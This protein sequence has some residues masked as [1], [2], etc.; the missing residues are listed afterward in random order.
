MKKIKNALI[1]VYNKNGIDKIARLLDGNGVQIY[2]TGGTHTFISKLGIEAKTIEGLTSYPSILGGRVKTLHPLVF[3]GILYQRDLQSDIE[4]I[5]EYNIPDFDLVIVDLYPFEKTVKE[6]TDEEQ[7]IE[8]IDIGGISLIR[9]AAKNFKDV[10][11]VSDYSQYPQLIEMIKQNNGSSSIEERR[12]FANFAFHT[13]SHY[14]TQ[15]FNYFNKTENLDFF[16]QSFTTSKTLRYGE[17]PHQEAKFYGDFSAMFD[18]LNGKEVSYNNI[19]D[20]EAAISLID[21]FEECSFAVLKHTNPCGLASRKTVVDSWKAALAGNSV[22]VFGGVLISNRK[23][24][25]EAA[26]EINKIFFE[27]LIAPNYDNPALEILKSKKN[28]ILLKQKPYIPQQKQIKTSLNGVLT[29]N[30]DTV[31]DKE[32]SFKTVT[33]TSPEKNEISDLVFA[34]IIVKHTKS[35]A[36]VLAKN[37]QLIGS[38]VGQTSRIDALKQAVGKAK[39]FKFSLDGAVMASDAFF[40]FSDSVELA[41][42]EG[43]T[44][45]IQ[46]GGSKRDQDSIEYCNNNNISMVFTGNRHF[47]H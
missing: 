14:D 9:A 36:I 23:I 18:Q 37:K 20:I 40:P 22:S 16:K 42:K 27:V 33:E 26:E 35:N 5:Q 15:I 25:Q 32:D 31:V 38:G 41:H 30:F 3:G 34:N 28:R 6:V 47:K 10:L 12:S 2:S 29:Q 45:I 7:I 44:S 1:S 19:Q 8:K 24:D 43:I 4:Q 46:P 39:A 17:N 21:D 13:S 11:V